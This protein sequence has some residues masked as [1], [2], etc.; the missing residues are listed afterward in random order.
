M[1]IH[2]QQWVHKCSRCKG[3]TA[4][5]F[6]V[7]L[8]RIYTR[9]T[10][11]PPHGRA[12]QRSTN[13]PPRMR[14]QIAAPC[15]HARKQAA[16]NLFPPSQSRSAQLCGSCFREKQ[17]G[18]ITYVQILASDTENEIHLL[19]PH[20]CQ[21]QYSISPVSY[22]RIV[23]R[24]APDS[25]TRIIVPTRHGA[26]GIRLSPGHSSIGGSAKVGRGRL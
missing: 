3:K 10:N 17:P 15:M 1:Y 21:H 14:G 4:A 25:R 16:R 22:L 8:R 7:D 20:Q 26:V 19:D 12:P 2:R 24:V 5:L 18:G 6:R 23:L 13:P 11:T 9:H